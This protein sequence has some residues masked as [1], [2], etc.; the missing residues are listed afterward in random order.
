MPNDA[1]LA[2]LT[3][4][5]KY[6]GAHKQRFDE[7][8]KGRGLAGRENVTHHDGSTESAVRSH[9]IE[10]T[11]DE[12]AHKKSVVKG[13]LGQQKF[14]TQADTP[15]SFMIYKNGDKN[16][17]GHKVLL[18]K[19]FRNMQQLTDECNKHAAPL[20]GPIRRFYRP[21]LKT[22]VKD[23]TEFEDGGKY[24]CVAGEN[25]KDDI[26]KIPPGFFE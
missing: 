10:K 14:G 25:P 22:W 13:P 3:D 18:K 16:H 8:G 19:H 5:S 20:T 2:R 9:A 17:K 11:V 7:D 21:D 6:T 26:E 23:L 24:L 1:T 4:T 15:I 12:K